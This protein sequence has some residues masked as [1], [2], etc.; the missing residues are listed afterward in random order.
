MNIPSLTYILLHR[1]FAG[2]KVMIVCFEKQLSN[3]WYK[4]AA[5]IKELAI[6]LEGI[7]HIIIS[8]H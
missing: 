6:R 5:C 3:H 8:N 4:I 7:G 2:L 1:V